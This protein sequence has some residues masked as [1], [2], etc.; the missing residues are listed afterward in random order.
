[1]G[2]ISIEKVRR[3]KELEDKEIE[4][5]AKHTELIDVEQTL[6]KELNKKYGDGN[7]NPETGE[8]TPIEAPVEG[9]KE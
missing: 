9:P 4:L 1:M 5:M 6:F 7:Y 3:L 2:Q 8:F